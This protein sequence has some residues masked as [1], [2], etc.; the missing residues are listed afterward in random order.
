MARHECMRCRS[1]VRRR[2]C[3]AAAGEGCL[4]KPGAPRLYIALIS[5]TLSLDAF[6]GQ[7]SLQ[8]T[9]PA[10]PQPRR[11]PTECWPLL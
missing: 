2:H 10:Q 8:R 4:H 5:T 6:I 3:R 9:S 7:L 11:A 1:A